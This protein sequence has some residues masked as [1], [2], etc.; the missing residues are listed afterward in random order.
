LKGIFLIRYI[1]SE[2]GNGRGRSAP[3]GRKSPR[4]MLAGGEQ[5]NFKSVAYRKFRFSPKKIGVG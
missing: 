3:A 5:A 2:D 1:K 4:R